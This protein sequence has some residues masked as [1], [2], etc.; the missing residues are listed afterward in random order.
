MPAGAGFTVKTDRR[1]FQ[2]AKSGE[3]TWWGA[4][5]VGVSQRRGSVPWLKWLSVKESFPA[6]SGSEFPGNDRVP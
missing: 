6:G 4:V 3:Q 2:G 1:G 5:S